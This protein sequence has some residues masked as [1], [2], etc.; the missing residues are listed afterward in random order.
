MPAQLTISGAP[1]WSPRTRLLRGRIPAVLEAWLLD[2]GS[3]TDRMKRACRGHFEVR[4]VDEGWQRPRL[5][6]VRAL[7]MRYGMV[8]WVRQVQ[9]LCDGHPWVFARTIVPVTTLTGAQRRLAHLGNRPLGAFLFADPGMQRGPVE[10][11]AIRNGQA[12][13]SLATAGLR[14]KPAEIW[15]RRS[16]FRVGG[17]PLL[18]TE[19]F[20]PAIETVCPGP[21]PLPGT[22]R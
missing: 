2:T 5:D 22:C 6:E 12:M 3:L 8:G 19:I 15:G 10:V 9:L 4:V 11:A 20:L 17:K 18:V 1:A 21:L 13:F 14:R 16:V 7:G